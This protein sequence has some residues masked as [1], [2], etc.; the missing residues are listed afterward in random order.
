MVS[1]GCLAHVTIIKLIIIIIIIAAAFDVTGRKTSV[2]LSVIF[3][4]QPARQEIVSSPVI[5]ET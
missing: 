5:L 3:L 4:S 2:T 1:A